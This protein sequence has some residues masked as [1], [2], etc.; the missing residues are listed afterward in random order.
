[1]AILC[2]MGIISAYHENI[3]NS[4]TDFVLCIPV[5]ALMASEWHQ[6]SVK[7][8]KDTHNA[9]EFDNRTPLLIINR[10]DLMKHRDLLQTIIKT[11]DNND[12]IGSH[13]FLRSLVNQK[14]DCDD[15]NFYI[16][17]ISEDLDSVMVLLQGLGVRYTT[18][19][20]SK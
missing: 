7:K 13:L 4:I 1:M 19:D 17:I 20:I 8:L 9:K 12:D 2:L 3:H 11:S 5:T 16:A 18:F 15:F 6:I 10:A 14:H